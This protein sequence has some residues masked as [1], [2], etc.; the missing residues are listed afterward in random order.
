[1]SP[2]TKIHPVVVPVPEADR[3]LIGRSRV[4]TLSRRA[5]EALNHSARYSGHRLGPLL[6]DDRGAPKPCNG[7]YW[8]LTHKTHY[9]AAVTAP[10]RVGIDIERVKPCNSGLYARIAD[11][12][13]WALASTVSLPLFFRFWTAKEAVLK[14]ASSGLAGLSRCRVHKIVDHNLIELAYDD[15]IWTVTQRWIE[16]DHIV[17]VT[18]SNDEV[19]WHVASLK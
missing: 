7:L 3:R 17:A 19:R 4:E 6:K 10:H 9:V 13:E 14:A 5:R 8:S 11:P 16:D 18:T 2:L 1:M 12:A 15:K